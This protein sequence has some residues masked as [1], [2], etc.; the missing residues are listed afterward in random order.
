MRGE[1]FNEQNVYIV[2]FVK[3]RGGGELLYSF[4]LRQLLDVIFGGEGPGARRRLCGRGRAR[5]V[6]KVVLG[7]NVVTEPNSS[8]SSSNSSS[9]VVVTVVPPRDSSSS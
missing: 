3:S 7:V 6:V 5:N 8:N 2:E 1:Y 9:G 4:Q